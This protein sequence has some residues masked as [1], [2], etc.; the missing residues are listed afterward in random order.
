MLLGHEIEREDVILRGLHRVAEAGQGDLD[1]ANELMARGADLIPDFNDEGEVFELIDH[2]WRHHD[3]ELR[4]VAE[5]GLTV[6]I[7]DVTGELLKA[8]EGLVA[9]VEVSLR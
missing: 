5:V 4:S 3:G 1:Q 7:H 6:A 8:R 2:I 9:H